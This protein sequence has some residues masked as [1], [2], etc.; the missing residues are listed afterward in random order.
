LLEPLFDILPS[1]LPLCTFLPLSCL[2]LSPPP[3]LPPPSPFFLSS[4]D[5]I[6]RPN[7]PS[8]RA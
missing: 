3:P 7:T 6:L 8:S 1:L 2:S 5:S 4:S